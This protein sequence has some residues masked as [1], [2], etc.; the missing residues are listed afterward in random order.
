MVDPELGDSSEGKPAFIPLDC[1]GHRV[2][3]HLAA[4]SSGGDTS[5]LQIGHRRGAVHAVLG[6]QSGDRGALRIE[7]DQAIDLG[8]G[9][10]SEDGV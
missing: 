1:N 9:E 4:L 3:V 7:A 5:A 10:A 2:V 8:G 6:D